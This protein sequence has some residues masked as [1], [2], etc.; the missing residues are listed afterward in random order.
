VLCWNSCI[1]LGMVLNWGQNL[2]RLVIKIMFNAR[3][4]PYGNQF[5][6]RKRLVK[7]ISNL[8][9]GS[10]KVMGTIPD[11]VIG[12]YNW[13]NPSSLTMDL[14]STQPLTEMSTRNLPGDNGR[15]AHKADNLTA[16]CEPI[17][18]KTWEPRRLTIL[19]TST[20]CYR[21]SFLNNCNSSVW[22][23]I[24]GRRSWTFLEIIWYFA[25]KYPKI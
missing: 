23:K 24:W 25:F 9:G 21:E 1:W 3:I 16:I 20:P 8:W 10:G 12:F 5:L 19:W 11:E 6:W 17:V 15:P 2:S 18:Y 7:Y 22:L 4:N 14:G 13:P